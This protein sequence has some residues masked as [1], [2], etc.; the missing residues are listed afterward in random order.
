[1]STHTYEEINER[2]EKLESKTEKLTY[3]LGYRTAIYTPYHSFINLFSRPAPTAETIYAA[4]AIKMITD[5]LGI[6]FNHECAR[7]KLEP[8]PPPVE[9][10]EEDYADDES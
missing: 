6:R 5:H 1:V 4:E 10:D 2:L 7:N 3:D 9:H 8:I